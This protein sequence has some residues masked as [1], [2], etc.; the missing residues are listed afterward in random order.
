[1]LVCFSAEG[2][3][4]VFWACLSLLCGWGSL[5]IAF[6]DIFVYMVHHF[7]LL[8]LNSFN[9]RFD[10][11]VWWFEHSVSYLRVS[12]SVES[13]QSLY[14]PWLSPLRRWGSLT[15]IYTGKFIYMTHFFILLQVNSF[16]LKVDREG[17]WFEHSVLQLW[18]SLSSEVALNCFIALGFLCS[19]DGVI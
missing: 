19:K 2:A 5:T 18:V 1:M 7:I 11:E 16:D 12:L 14:W 17:F 6:T 4:N 10:R 3:K 8:Y 13:A 9:R 15:T